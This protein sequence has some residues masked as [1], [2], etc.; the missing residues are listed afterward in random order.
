M[1][2]DNLHEMSIFL[3]KIRKIF[4]MFSAE[5]FTQQA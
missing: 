4:Q 5:N 3:G 2:G 1:L